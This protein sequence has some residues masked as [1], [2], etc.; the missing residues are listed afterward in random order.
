MK[1]GVTVL[2]AVLIFGL[3][4]MLAGIALPWASKSIERSMMI[5]E[6]EQVKAEFELCNSKLIDTARTGTS[7][8]CYF[9]AAKGSVSAQK[10]GLYYKIIGPSDICNRH[11]W[12]ILNEEKHIWQR[13]SAAPGS[14][15]LE[16]SWYYPTS[17]KIYGNDLTGNII[18]DEDE[19]STREIVFADSTAV[20][21]TLT[22]LVEFNFK[23]GQQGKSVIINRV[24]IT[25]D[26][27]ILNVEIS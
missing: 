14:R 7:N 21:R 11:K 23:E 5:S 2:Q 27:T 4:A 1:G 15:I 9:S 16:L 24:G 10:E 6:I 12:F 3:V 8:R 18:V 22:V 25:E 17:L 13:C 26:K 20:F 19:T